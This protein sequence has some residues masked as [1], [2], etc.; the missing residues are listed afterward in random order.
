MGIAYY[1]LDWFFVKPK[2]GR[3]APFNGQT[4]KLVN[5][6]YGNRISDHDPIT[7]DLKL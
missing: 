1:K 7:V 2:R 5:E 3:F 4:L 6:A